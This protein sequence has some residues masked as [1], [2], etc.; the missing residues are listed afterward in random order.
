MIFYDF[1]VFEKDWLVVMI[2]VDLDKRTQKEYIICNNEEELKTFYENNKNDIWIGYNSKNYDQYILKGILC[3]FNPKEISDYIIVKGKHGW[4]FSHLLSKIQVINYDIIEL[5]DGGLKFLEA[6][7]GNDIKETSVPFNIKRKLTDEEIEETKKYCEHDVKQTIEV[8]VQ[9][10]NGLSA[11][12]ELVNLA[13]RDTE[14]DSRLISKSKPQLSAKILGAE[15]KEHNDEFDFDFPNTLEIKKYTEVLDFYKNPENKCY[16]RKIEGRK[17]QENVQFIIDVAG[18]KHQ[19][20]YGGVHGAIPKYQGEGYFLNMD[21]ASLYPSLMI[22]YNL[23]SRNMRN[24]NKFKEI[25]EE[26]LALKKAKNPLQSVLKLVLNSTYGVMKDRN[27]ALYD[28]LQANRVCV[29]G[30]LLLLD[31]IEKLE[32]YCEIIQSNTDGV[33]VKLP[34]KSKEEVYAVCKEW[35]DRT[36][37]KLEFEDFVKVF[38][39]DVNNY[40]L[41]KENGE[42]KAKGAYVKNL[43]SLNYNLPIV[44][45]AILN[46]LVSQIPVEE[47]IKQC[48]LL[49]EFQFI[50]KISNKFE[51]LTINDS[52]IKERCVRVFAST[53]THDGEIRKISMGSKKSMKVSEAPEKIFISNYNINNLKIPPKL[54]K[55]W[56]I[57]L[58]KK[59]LNDFG[60]DVGI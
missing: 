36:R 26:R 60:I 28:P 58:A 34:S 40:V 14:F 51:A 49:K 43:N 50:V 7:M 37:L 42:H 17:T 31:L 29:Y 56:Y 6:S 23:H 10:A 32:P 33:L 19:F 59:R 8:F 9:R 24:P 53:D 25:Y 3:G 11:Q 52:P 21:V 13:C 38:Q 18:V 35:Q 4:E 27:N 15:F 39:K 41:V 57:N 1:E 22:E 5:N 2:S 47:T 16:K 54:D 20:G 55:N 46:Y 44:N 30:Q 45:R 12:I 48:K